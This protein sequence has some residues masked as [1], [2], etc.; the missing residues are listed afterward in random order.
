MI[1]TW[2]GGGVI[3]VLGRVRA[4]RSLLSALTAARSLVRPAS[5]HRRGSGL[6]GMC[7]LLE[8]VQPLATRPPCR[9]AAQVHHDQLQV[10]EWPCHSEYWTQ[11]STGTVWDSH[12]SCQATCDGTARRLM[13]MAS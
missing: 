12:D 9:M 6:K 2:F 8:T 11:T 3:T 7:M 4:T 1:W 10:S 13:P 5:R